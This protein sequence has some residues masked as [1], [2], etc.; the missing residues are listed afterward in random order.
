MRLERIILGQSPAFMQKSAPHFNLIL[1][2]F[3]KLLEVITL[4][5]R[6]SLKYNRFLMLLCPGFDDNV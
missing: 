4:L 6:C 3:C 2:L 5:F 1:R